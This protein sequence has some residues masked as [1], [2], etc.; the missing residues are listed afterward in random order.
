MNH[1]S[2]D[3]VQWPLSNLTPPELKKSIPSQILDIQKTNG[4]FSVH[5]M[6][7]HYTFLYK[8]K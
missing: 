2:C 3:F 4:V 5:D 8:N 6:V 7:N 1:D